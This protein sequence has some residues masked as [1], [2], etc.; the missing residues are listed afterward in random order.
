MTSSTQAKMSREGLIALVS[1]EVAGRRG[2]S[3]VLI[4]VSIRRKEVPP[5]PNTLR[6]ILCLVSHS[7]SPI[8]PEMV[9]LS[10]RGNL[11]IDYVYVVVR[12]YVPNPEH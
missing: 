2:R 4:L 12:R 5:K 3:P 11:E 7:L 8:N 1:G 9:A 6:N 10:F